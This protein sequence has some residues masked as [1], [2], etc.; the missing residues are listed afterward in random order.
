MSDYAVL[1]FNLGPQASNPKILPNKPR[2][3]FIFPI[4]FDV[5]GSTQGV[6]IACIQHAS[7]APPGSH[8][9]SL[10]HFN[11]AYLLKGPVYRFFTVPYCSG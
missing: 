6:D 4:S 1:K 3:N 5:L 8:R 2:P 11:V 10:F 9:I 7:Y